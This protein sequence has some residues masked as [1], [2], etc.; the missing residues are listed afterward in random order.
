MDVLETFARTQGLRAAFTPNVKGEIS[1]FFDEMEPDEF[2][3]AIYAAY[4]VEW[5]LM[6]DVVHFY[7]RRD[8]E[9]RMIYLTA[10]VPTKMRDILVGA[11]LLSPQLPCVADDEDKVLTFSGPREYAEGVVAAISSYETA[12]RNDQV[13]KVFFLKHAWAEDTV[14]GSGDSKQTIPGVATILSE[15]IM[16][17]KLGDTQLAMGSGQGAAVRETIPPLPEEMEQLAP[18]NPD[19]NSA[20]ERLR[21]QAKEQMELDRRVAAPLNTQAQ[22]M[23]ATPTRELEPKILAD[24]RSNAVIV[25]DSAYR[26]SYYEQ[27][28]KEL[29]KPLQLVELHAAIVDVDVDFSS[30]IGAEWGGAGHGEYTNTGVGSNMAKALAGSDFPGALVGSG[31]TLSTVYTFG[32]DYFMAQVS[33]LETRGKGRVLG[34]PSVLTIDNT[35]ARLETSTTFYIRI[36]GEKVVDLQEVSSGTVLDVTPHVI[37][38]DDKP[39]QIKLAVTIEDGNAPSTGDTDSDIPAVTKK[40]VV[41]TQGIVS[42]GQSLL[43]GGYF[44]ETVNE[45]DTGVPGLMEIPVLG[46]LFRTRTQTSQRMER[47]VLLSPR[48]LRLGSD[49]NVPED[50][51][52]LGFAV[53]PTSPEFAKPDITKESQGV[54]GCTRRASGTL[55]SGKV[56]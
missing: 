41:R 40:T 42:E 46:A 31:L 15:M 6:D 28:I 55:D 14:L 33:A 11:G 22:Q 39:A 29:D 3:A 24:S 43:V 56:Q 1:G 38:Y 26:M 12:F 2:L 32:A 49:T 21:R 10:C 35:S 47:L 25:R 37:Y 5:Y 16:Q 45:D 18:D 52:D 34:R 7:V 8:L 50:L 44:Y 20:L 53:S 30:A 23:P 48:I 27:T 13:V 17:N 36:V 19:R 9:R 54:G 4:G 51:K